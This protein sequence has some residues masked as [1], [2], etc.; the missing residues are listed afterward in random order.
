M[1]HTS[2]SPVRLTVDL[3]NHSSVLTLSDQ[4]QLSTD[5][6]TS[7]GRAGSSVATVSTSSRERTCHTNIVRLVMCHTCHTLRHT[8]LLQPR[9][10]A[11]GPLDVDEA[12]QHRHQVVGGPQQP[13]GQEVVGGAACTVSLYTRVPLHVT[14]P[15]RC[16][17]RSC[18]PA[19]ARGRP[20]GR[21]G[22]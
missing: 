17:P 7:S 20:R 15:W 22:R 13:R 9:Q 1:M 6:T 16:R 5:L 11:G 2:T 8:D 10:P 19:R 3:T 18:G 4:S 12:H 21:R 14:H